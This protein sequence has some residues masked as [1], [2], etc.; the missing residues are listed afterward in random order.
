M[1]EIETI[2]GDLR[3]VAQL[4][5]GTFQHWNELSRDQIRNVSLRN[6][7][8]YVADFPLYTAAGGKAILGLARHTVAHPNNLI[9]THLFDPKNSSYEQLISRGDFR[10]DPDEARAVLE[11]AD[12]LKVEL[13]GLRLGVYDGTSCFLSI[14]TQDGFIRV[15]DKFKRPNE[16]EQAVLQRVGYTPDFLDMMKSDPHTISETRVNVLNPNY[17]ENEA[18]EGFI[19]RAAWRYLFVFNTPSLPYDYRVN[20]HLGVRGVR[21]MVAAGDAPKNVEVPLAASAHSSPKPKFFTPERGELSKR[22]QK[23]ELD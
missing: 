4:E 15:G 12:T 22:V 8:L 19:S 7:A 21:R 3:A 23:L 13:S 9:L 11:A 2:T 17:V 16:L 14:R 18:E 6:R 5:Q 1:P 20:V 10:P